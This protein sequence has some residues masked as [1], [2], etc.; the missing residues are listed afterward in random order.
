MPG[1]HHHQYD[2][3]GYPIPPADAPPTQ[4]GYDPNYFPPPPRSETGIYEDAAGYPSAERG[5]NQTERGSV[6]DGGGGG[7]AQ[8]TPYDEEKAYAEYTNAYG[9]P[10][11]GHHNYGHQRAPP[12]PMSDY[13]APRSRRRSDWDREAEDE[14]DRR[15]YE[16]SMRRR[17]ASPPPSTSAAYDSDENLSTR[18]SLPP[19]RSSV[20]RRRNSS[21]K[22]LSRKDAFLQGSGDRGFGATLLG[23]AAGAFLGDHIGDKKKGDKT[24]LKTIGGALVG[25][26]GANAIER[27]VD[28]R[29]REKQRRDREVYYGRNDSYDDLYR[30]ARDPSPFRPR[31]DSRRSLSRSRRGSFESDYRTE[32][33]R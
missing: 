30:G 24:F 28:K 15:R 12:P 17:H 11:Y 9:H 27:Q 14:E 33:T 10:N 21:E 1:P 29:E 25:A 32:Y 26:I 6:S 16:E 23:G 7:A 8:L 22:K 20:S 18:T 31:R 13:T 2:R 5:Y 19:S 3:D 4:G